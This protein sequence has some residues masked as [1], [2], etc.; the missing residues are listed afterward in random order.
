MGRS[1]ARRGAESLAED[2]PEGNRPNS[3][4]EGVRQ[5]SPRFP[6]RWLAILQK[7]DVHLFTPRA[8]LSAGHVARMDEREIRFE[9]VNNRETRSRYVA[10]TVR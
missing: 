9:M 6:T 2:Q 1:A 3:I 10:K 5:K 7:A 8:P 4:R